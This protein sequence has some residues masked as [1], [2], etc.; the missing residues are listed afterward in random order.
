[1]FASEDGL[2]GAP[3]SHITARLHL[4]HLSLEACPV[5]VVGAPSATIPVPTRDIVLVFGVT[6]TLHRLDRG[7]G[8]DTEALKACI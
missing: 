1:M 4:I 5:V 6:Q 3:F 8:T 2:R 7:V